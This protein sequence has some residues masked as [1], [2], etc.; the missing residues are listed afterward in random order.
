MYLTRFF[1]DDPQHGCANCRRDAG[2]LDLELHMAFQPIV[3]VARR[4]VFAYEALVRGPDGQPAAWVLDRITPET[5]YRFDQTCRVLA[6]DTASKLGLGDARL[7]INFIP[8]AVYE[9]AS[10]LRL[11]LAA[12]DRVGLPMDRLMFE[13]T[14]SERIVDP[15]H[16]LSILAY[17]HRRGFVTAVDD[18]GAGFAGLQ[19]LVQFQP[20]ILKIDM[21]LVRGI[22]HHRPRQAVVSGTLAIARELGAQ[23]VAEGVETEGEYAWLRAAGVRLFQGYWFARPQIEALPQPDWARVG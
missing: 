21:E 14:E 16:A 23:V 6:I 20:Q 15:Q 18:F 3:D 2:L 8:N 12:A 1:A 11:T 10:C 22:D 17:Y 9:P 7:S 13:L 19:L 5:L 4:E